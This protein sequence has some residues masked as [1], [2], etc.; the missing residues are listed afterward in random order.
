MEPPRK[1][2]GNPV[3]R[4]VSTMEEGIGMQ[5]KQV[6][7]LTEVQAQAGTPQTTILQKIDKKAE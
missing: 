4:R 3:V 6:E 7:R 1:S 2:S 5:L